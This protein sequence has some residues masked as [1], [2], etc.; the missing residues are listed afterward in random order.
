MALQS[1]LHIGGNW[2]NVQDLDYKIIQPTD[3]VGKPTAIPE[4]GLIN[5]TILA[6][7]KDNNF[8]Q[9]WV[10]SIAQRESG[11]FYLP[12]TNGIEHDEIVL[13]FEDAFCTDLQVWYGSFN[14]KQ[15]YMRLT[16]TP[17]RLIFGVGVEFVNKKIDK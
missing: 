7:N 12:V 14:E 1:V 13:E 9:K 11:T 2:Y 15:L 17:T 3:S 4:G 6:N 16:I 8:F 10:L 5:F